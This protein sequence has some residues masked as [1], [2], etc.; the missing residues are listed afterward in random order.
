MSRTDRKE[1][2]MAGKTK[3]D[4][5]NSHRVE[6]RWDG[7]LVA[8]FSTPVP[9]PADAKEAI[10][11]LKELVAILEAPDMPDPDVLGKYSPS[12]GKIL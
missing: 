2:K 12:N 5:L 1:L 8:G 7:V 6:L 10:N 11:F 3:I 4:I 9:R